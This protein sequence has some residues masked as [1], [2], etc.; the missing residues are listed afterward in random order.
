M[1]TT[2]KLAYF[3]VAVLSNVFCLTSCTS[4][5]VNPNYDAERGVVKTE[6][7][8][9]IPAKPAGTRMTAT[10]V[11]ATGDLANF[12]GI[13]DIKLY[14]FL[15]K[16]GEI[17]TATQKPAVINLVGNT[18]VSPQGASGTVD[19]TIASSQ[20]ATALKSGSNSHLYKDVEIEIG[21]QS[22][23]FYGMAIPSY[24][25]AN[26]T[27]SQL[28]ANGT[29]SDNLSDSTTTTLGDI[30]FSPVKIYNGS[31][32]GNATAILSY[33]DGIAKA[34][35]WRESNNV[36]LQTLYQK[37]ITMRAGSWA[38]V[39][40]AVQ[41]LY[42]TLYNKTFVAD[43]DNTVKTNIINKILDTQASDAGGGTLTFR[44]LYDFPADLSLPDGAIYLSWSTTDN[45]FTIVDF[46]GAEY[47]GVV[48]PSGTTLVG[49]YER[50]GTEGNYTYTAYTSGTANG[51]ST[52]YKKSSDNTGLDIPNLNK[53]VYP[54]PLYYRA[55]SN[56]RTA[57]ASKADVYSTAATWDAVL[58]GYGAE[59]PGQND[60]VISTTRSIAIV[61]QVQYAVG[62]LDAIVRTDGATKLMDYT[63]TEIPIKSNDA[64]PTYYFPVTGI[65]IGGQ[66]AVD[67]K[68]AQKSGGEAYT[69]YDNDIP[70]GISLTDNT[71]ANTATPIHTLVFETADATKDNDENAIVNIAVEFQNNSGDLFVG[72]YG[73]IIYP[74]SKF[75]LLGTF[76]PN[77]NTT[78]N[79]IGVT[80]ATLI[81]KAF[82]QDYTTTA[83]LVISSLRN[84][85]NTMPDL[86]A[87]QLELGLSVD[88]TW[89]TGISQT[90]TIP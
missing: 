46:P 45:K 13:K 41:Q 84:A 59:V 32:G 48:L 34:S 44:P 57:N 31:L 58:S 42:K 73:E 51:T 68:F 88:L 90:I 79:Y 70:T 1:K 26:P 71:D 9:S 19:N 54:A 17:T 82:V 40:G 3:C 39:K 18:S 76:D 87:P 16:A 81:K 49:Y 69:I 83:N 56:I 43:A 72:R 62:R 6:F 64:T 61:D 4:E 65:L 74:G 78:V 15:P 23:M 28:I 60:K 50:S 33:L 20:D 27:S 77:K 66:K 36:I 24:G 75:Y 47:S 52:Y 63:G 21:T 10:T 80:P 29:L 85:Y 38:S 7:T 14:P 12:R 86:R 89:Q 25:N 55:L 67:Y 37:F 2:K 5:E 30:T 22:F 11:Q 35:G 53:Y 8:I